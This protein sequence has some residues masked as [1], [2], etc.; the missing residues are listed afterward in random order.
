[1]IDRKDSIQAMRTSVTNGGLVF[2]QKYFQKSGINSTPE[3]NHPKTTFSPAIHH[4]LTTKNHH[5]PTCFLKN[6]L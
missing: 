3:N 5:D 1:M 6:P 4:K 2:P